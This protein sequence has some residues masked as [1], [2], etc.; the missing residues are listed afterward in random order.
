MMRDILIQYIETLESDGLAPYS[1]TIP[2][3]CDVGD[4]TTIFV[5]VNR[6]DSGL[7]WRFYDA[8]GALIAVVNPG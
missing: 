6:S 4:E 7:P 8:G 1:V 3:G 2:T 5:E